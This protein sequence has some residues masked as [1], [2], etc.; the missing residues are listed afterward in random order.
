MKKQFQILATTIIS[1]AIVSCSKQGV[2]TPA[3]QQNV[4]EEIS[5]SSSSS[6]RPVVDPLTVGLEGWFTFNHNLSDQTKKL[7][8]AAP[9]LGRAVSYTYDRHGISNSAL[10]LDSSY[11]LKILFVV[12][13]HYQ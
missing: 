11:Y 5:T 6:L 4:T 10:K 8:D 12:H 1:I 2:E 7:K 13:P 9:A 3:T